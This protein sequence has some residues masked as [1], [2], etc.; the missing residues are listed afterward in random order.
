MK[1]ITLGTSH[2]DPTYC[3]HCSSTL[4]QLSDDMGY[5][6]DA[7][8][9]ANALMIRKGL[10]L[11]MLRAVFIT[12]QHED[13][14]GGLPGVLKTLVKYPKRDGATTDILLPEQSGIDATLAFMAAT[15]RGWPPELLTFRVL[16]SAACCYADDLVRVST[17]PTEHMGASPSYGFLVETEGKR[18]VFSGDLHASFRDFPLRAGDDPCDLCICECVHY[19]LEDALPKLKQLPIKRMIFNHIGDAWHGE[20]NERRFRELVAE[21]PFP[22]TMAFDGDEFTV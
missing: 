6:I 15:G 21:L 9:P 19:R 14:M 13:H 5:L 16:P 17:L 22:A 4:L 11:T 12:H 8:A 10:Q 18:V 7:G 2:G 20:D 3:R 1:I